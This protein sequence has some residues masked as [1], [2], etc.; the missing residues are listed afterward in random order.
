M[1]VM[2]KITD[3][4]DSRKLLRATPAPS[5]NSGKHQNGST[6][7]HEVLGFIETTVV[8]IFIFAEIS[9]KHTYF[10]LSYRYDFYRF[11]ERER[12]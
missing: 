9:D 2:K 7:A 1:K 11:T 12:V 6:K 10:I 5:M 8:S 4:Y 3:K